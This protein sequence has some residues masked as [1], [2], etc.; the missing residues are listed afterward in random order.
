[1]KRRL[2]LGALG[3][4]GLSGSDTAS[5]TEPPATAEPDKHQRVVVVGGGWAGLSFA[6]ELR[7]RAPELDI[8]LL[9]RDPTLR[10]LPLSN[11]WL[12]G[13]T[14]ERLA[15]IDL[16][17]LGKT[18]GFRFVQA[19]VLSIQRTQ[20]Q[21]LTSRGAVAYDWLLLADGLVY[22][23]AAWF[24]E[25]QRAASAARAKFPAGFVANE[26]GLL[27]RQLDAFTGGN[28]VMTIPPPPFRCP[29]APYERAMLI[30]WMLKSRRIS[31]K[32]MVLDAG[33]GP[34]RFTRLFAER[35]PNQIVYRPHTSGLTIDPFA[36][37][38]STDEGDL[39]FEHAILLPP[40][41]TSQLLASAGLV[42]VNAQGQPTAWAGV[43][44]MR[45]CSPLDDRVYLAG[46]LLGAVSPLF[47]HYP[48]TAHM[49]TRL[50]AAAAQQIAA[51]SR[52]LTP[53]PATLPESVCH[54]W[55]DGDPAEQLRIETRYRLRGDGLIVQTVQQFDNPQ[56]RDEDLHWGRTLYTDSLG[57]PAS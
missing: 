22:D 56:P 36:H 44:P 9:D 4:W 31:G 48:K 45:L 43:D 49:A 39:R 54:V 41:R 51:R 50:G 23:Y 19:E 6:R 17:A 33:A 2:V 16:A 28:L 35:Y 40:M 25:D 15:P 29:P 38:L 20:R 13:R 1:M 8:V 10:A 7:L 30:G 5:A 32:L 55:L 52:G 12:V 27:K 47:G 42:G 46:D 18:S 34:P 57:V 14:P 53:A 3:A 21:V 11:P 37:R 26:L 24:G